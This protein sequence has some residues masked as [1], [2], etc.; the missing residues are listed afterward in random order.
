MP[1]TASLTIAHGWVPRQDNFLGSQYYL[2]TYLRALNRGPHSSQL[3]RTQKSKEEGR[4]K[5][6]VF[7]VAVPSAR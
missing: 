7:G 1:T 2:D 4:A 5:G 3:P 6:Y